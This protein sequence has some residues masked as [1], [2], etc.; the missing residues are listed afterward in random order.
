MDD[1]FSLADGEC[2]I[3]RDFKV[4]HLHRTRNSFQHGDGTGAAGSL[5]HMHPYTELGDRNKALFYS[6]A[7]T[8]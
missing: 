4:I 7:E 2:V 8:D 6:S 1:P 3:L 5:H